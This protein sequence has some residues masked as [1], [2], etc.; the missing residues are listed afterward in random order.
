MA[1]NA[2]T[3]DV[4]HSCDHVH[5]RPLMAWSFRTKRMEPVASRLAWLREQEAP[6]FLIEKTA[7]REAKLA[8]SCRRYW[9]DKP[10]PT[11]YAAQVPQ[12]VAA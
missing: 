3:L 1:W 6:R 9:Q 7:E 4:R 10:C 8:E 2:S 12:A 5:P 11:C